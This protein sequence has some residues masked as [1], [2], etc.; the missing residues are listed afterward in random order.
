LIIM[1]WDF[2]NSRIFYFKKKYQDI[3]KEFLK[4]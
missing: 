4:N 2:Y 1:S 3:K